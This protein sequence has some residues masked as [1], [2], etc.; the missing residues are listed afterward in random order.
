MNVLSVD[1]DVL[2]Q[3]YTDA[4]SKVPTVFDDTYNFNDHL[5][6]SDFVTRHVR[7]KLMWI[8]SW[9]FMDMIKDELSFIKYEN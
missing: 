8:S 7:C 2:E 3:I 6:R 9:D 1:E 4:S 5:Y